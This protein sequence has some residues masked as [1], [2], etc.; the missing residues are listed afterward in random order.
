ME[1]QANE[2]KQIGIFRLLLPI[3]YLYMLALLT[4]FI[5]FS[6]NCYCQ[7]KVLQFKHL[8]SDDGLSNSQVICILQDYRGFMW[9]GTYDGLNRYD[10]TNIVIYKNNPYDSGSISSNYAQTL[11][12]DHQHR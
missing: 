9:L 10:G 1:E 12:E 8:T 6:L 2:M 11:Y 3:G 4:V 7:G 5:F